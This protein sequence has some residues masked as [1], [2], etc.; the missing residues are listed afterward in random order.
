LQ[1]SDCVNGSDQEIAHA[2]RGGAPADTALVTFSNSQFS[3]L[4]DGLRPG[5][6]YR[7]SRHRQAGWHLRRAP[8]HRHL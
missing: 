2:R 8:S 1:P 4:C 6:V 7:R 5:V 3:P